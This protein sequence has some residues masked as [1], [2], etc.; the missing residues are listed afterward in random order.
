M[1]LANKIIESK[2]YENATELCSIMKRHGSDKGLGHHNYTT[3]YEPLLQHLKETSNVILFELGIG[4][5]NPNIVSN[6]GIHG[7]PGASLY[8]W[9]E[10]LPNARIIG[11]D[12]DKDILFK[13]DNIETYYVDQRDPTVI[14][15]MW[16]QC[17]KP[18]DVI[19]DDGLH[20]FAANDIF[21]RNS[22]RHLKPNGL[23]IVEDIIPGD[24]SRFE[25]VIQ[26]YKQW[27]SDVCIVTLPNQKNNHDNRLLICQ[28]PF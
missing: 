28:N 27:F 25:R 9:S 10:W 26:D 22:H 21:I 8:G 3:L 17:S 24:V 18:V 6:M 7:H 1:E 15:D 16:S 19:I 5:N 20:E 14:A 13:T 11:A 12:I 23:Y 4:T 2:A